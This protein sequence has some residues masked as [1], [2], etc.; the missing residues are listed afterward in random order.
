MNQFSFRKSNLNVNR[1]EK[2]NENISPSSTISHSKMSENCLSSKS[3][4]KK[5]PSFKIKCNCFEKN[6]VT[7]VMKNHFS[8]KERTSETDSK[9]GKIQLIR[10]GSLSS[11]LS[12]K[13]KGN[14]CMNQ[15]SCSLLN[16]LVCYFYFFWKSQFKNKP[17]EMC[18]FTH[19]FGFQKCEKETLL[20]KLSEISEFQKSFSATLMIENFMLNPE[21]F[22][23]RYS[24]YDLNWNER[25]IAILFL[26]KK[27]SFLSPP[28]CFCNQTLTAF[29]RKKS[30]KRKHELIRFCIKKFTNFIIEKCI[31]TKYQSQSNSD[32]RKLFYKILNESI[33]GSS[34]KNLIKTYFNE[35]IKVK[36]SKRRRLKN[37]KELIH[38]L[39][40]NPITESFF[41]K[42]MLHH[43]FFKIYQLYHPERKLKV[44][45]FLS[46][47]ENFDSLNVFEKSL[48]L[49][50]NKRIK[51]FFGHEDIKAGYNIIFE[52]LD[53]KTDFDN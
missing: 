28:T 19:R 26:I 44:R 25:I 13:N 4:E 9:K 43:N 14:P 27:N 3:Q 50:E 24:F 23:R 6:E 12:I 40:T 11:L 33:P 48:D 46:R 53:T 15:K 47:F 22:L 16:S 17:L 2:N 32:K 34:S 21:I 42:K 18:Q 49:L 51:L 31:P 35:E 45:N 39:S 20:K 8:T 52:M 7:C 5:L 29:I 37:I 1:F 30:T 41:D 38:K 36:N 10:L